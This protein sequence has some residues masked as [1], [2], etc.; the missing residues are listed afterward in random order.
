MK[1]EGGVTRVRGAG[2]QVAMNVCNIRVIRA[3]RVIKG[4]RI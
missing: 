1:E 2:T 3:V 4:C